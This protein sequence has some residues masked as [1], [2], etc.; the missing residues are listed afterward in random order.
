MLIANYIKTMF[1]KQVP[2]ERKDM[3]LHRVGSGS[4]VRY[5]LTSRPT[6]KVEWVSLEA[7]E[8]GKPLVVR[9]PNESTREYSREGKFTLAGK[10]YKDLNHF[11][12]KTNDEWAEDIYG[13]RVL[14]TKER[15][16]CFDSDD[17]L[18]ETRYFR[19]YFVQKGA[20][21]SLLFV[22]DDRDKIYAT[23]DVQNVDSWAWDR[24]KANGF[25]QPSRH[26]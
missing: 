12:R 4:M 10:T 17:Y 5:E 3:Y 19:W 14:C 13:R 20:S 22:S 6:E 21:I 9:E 18:Y 24:M 25:C 23:E 8:N 16:P 2:Q 15:Y 1:G 26:T 11:L 7:D